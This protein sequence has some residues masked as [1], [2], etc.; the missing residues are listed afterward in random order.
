[1][2][3]TARKSP[4]RL[5]SVSDVDSDLAHF[6]SGNPAGETLVEAAEQAPTANRVTAQKGCG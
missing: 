6:L 4:N 5:V 3:F 1:L 2:P